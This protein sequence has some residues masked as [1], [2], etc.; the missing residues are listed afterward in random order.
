MSFNQ[1]I[2]FCY[3]EFFLIIA[4]SAKAMRTSSAKTFQR[5]SSGA[6]GL[7]NNAS[8]FSNLAISSCCFLYSFICAWRVSASAL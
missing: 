1:D 8:S 7:C 3:L 4:H 6:E 5:L 2:F